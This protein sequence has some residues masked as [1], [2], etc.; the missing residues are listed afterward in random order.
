MTRIGWVLVAL[1]SVLLIIGWYLLIFAP[2]SEDIEATR[3]QRDSVLAEAQAQRGLAQSL[4]QVREQA[5]E[6]ESELAFGR[7]IIPDEP[8]IPSLFRQMQQAADDAGVRLVSISPSAPA[9]V[10]LDEQTVTA[11]AVTMS[12]EATY[13]Q[14]VDLARRIEDPTLTPRALTW[15][16][17]SISPGE[18]PTLNATLSGTVY[19]RTGLIAS[20]PE[21][22][23]AETEA[24]DED[25]EAD[26]D[27]GEPEPPEAPPADEEG[28]VQ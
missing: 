1:L 10:E 5:P 3:D 7:S 14:L 26:P 27:S 23:E 12:V 28:E 13:F 19:S 25:P 8:A 21:E 22:D 2:T 20:E 4:R 17:A 6:A 24:T 18:L 16:T 11:V 9:P 15:Q